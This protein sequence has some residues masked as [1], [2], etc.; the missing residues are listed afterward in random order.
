VTT[1]SDCRSIS[2]HGQLVEGPMQNLLSR[3]AFRNVNN[4]SVGIMRS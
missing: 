4:L 1:G 2:V 3:L